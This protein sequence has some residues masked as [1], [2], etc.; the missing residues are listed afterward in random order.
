M[1]CHVLVP[2]QPIL[3]QES[4]KRGG[5]WITLNMHTHFPIPPQ[6][7][8]KG[9]CAGNVCPAPAVRHCEGQSLVARGLGRGVVYRPQEE[10]L[11]F[12]EVRIAGMIKVLRTA[13]HP[14]K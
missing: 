12:G 3:S 2:L 11:S 5:G 6:L 13:T 4:G 14:Q 1:S 8:G 7:K 9:W 10:I